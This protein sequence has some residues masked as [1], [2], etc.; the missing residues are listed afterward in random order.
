[1]LPTTYLRSSSFEAEPEIEILVLVIFFRAF[2]Q[3]KL[4][5]VEGSRIDRGE[6]EQRC[7]S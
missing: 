7:G 5:G 6:A 4:K 1:M 3:E 2:S